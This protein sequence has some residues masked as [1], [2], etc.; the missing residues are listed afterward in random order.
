MITQNT[1]K[2]FTVC[3]KEGEP[4]GLHFNQTAMAKYQ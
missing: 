1:M 4:T 3:E 2:T